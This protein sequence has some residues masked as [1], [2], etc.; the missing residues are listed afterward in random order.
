[1]FRFHQITFPSVDSFCFNETGVY[2]RNKTDRSEFE[3]IKR[4]HT[5]TMVGL[6][7]KNLYKLT[8]IST[9]INILNSLMSRFAMLKKRYPSKHYTK[10]LDPISDLMA[11]DVKFAY[12]LKSYYDSKLPNLD[13]PKFGIETDTELEKLDDLIRNLD[14]SNKNPIMVFHN[15]KI[16][17]IYSQ[18]IILPSKITLN[19]HSKLINDSRSTSTLY[20]DIILPFDDKD[21]IYHLNPNNCTHRRDLPSFFA[22]HS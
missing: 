10:L 18:K 6:L 11:D 15:A 1:M 12:L 9:S 21:H 19:S 4:E 17:T 22:D 14:L 2:F 5:N 16:D 3:S 7:S 13:L 20:Y 8:T